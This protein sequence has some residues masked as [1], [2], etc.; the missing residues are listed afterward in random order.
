MTEE[1]MICGFEI[2]ADN[3]VFKR[4][5]ALDPDRVK[6]ALDPSDIRDDPGLAH[7]YPISI[8]AAQQLTGEQVPPADYFV[9]AVQALDPREVGPG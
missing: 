9:N 4:V 5:L 8:E 6:T 3:L 1:Y 2:G 7:S